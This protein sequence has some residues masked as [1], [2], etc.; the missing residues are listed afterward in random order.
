[1]NE[2]TRLLICSRRSKLSGIIRLPKSR[3]WWILCQGR[4][5][6]TGDS[7]SRTKGKPGLNRGDFRGNDA[8][9]IYSGFTRRSSL[10]AGMNP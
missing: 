9:E 8:R 4:P 7:P 1:M 5:S 6:A 2:I 3:L 10:L